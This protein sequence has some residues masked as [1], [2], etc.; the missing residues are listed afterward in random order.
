MKP[1]VEDKILDNLPI[2]EGSEVYK[3]WKDPPVTPVVS[4]RVFNLTNLD[5]F[6]KGTVITAK[7]FQPLSLIKFQG[8]IYLIL[9][10]NFHQ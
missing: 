10:S 2:R 8:P 3:G 6:L 9:T 4:F 5:A 7:C 1:F